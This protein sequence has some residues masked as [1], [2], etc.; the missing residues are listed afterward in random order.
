MSLGLV[1]ALGL[2]TGSLGPVFPS[3]SVLDQTARQLLIGCPWAVAFPGTDLT[4]LAQFCQTE[5]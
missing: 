1:K 4:R 5:T 2:S 3:H